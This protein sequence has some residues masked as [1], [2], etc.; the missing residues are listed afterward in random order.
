MGSARSPQSQT[1]RM[2]K[3]A[4]VQHSVPHG[5]PGEQDPAL[6]LPELWLPAESWQEL[7]LYQQDQIA[8]NKLTQIIKRISQDLVLPTTGR[9]V[10]RRHNEDIFFQSCFTTPMDTVRLYNVS[11]ATN[12]PHTPIREG[13]QGPDSFSQLWPLDLCGWFSHCGT[14][15]ANSVFYLLPKLTEELFCQ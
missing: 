15:S 11:R 10:V 13:C 9:A 1:E 3:A 12:A 4:K 7:T 6:C 8:V 5:R 14:A 2:S